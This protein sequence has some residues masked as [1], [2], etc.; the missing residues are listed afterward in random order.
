MPKLALIIFIKV[1]IPGLVK[2]RLSQT[3]CLDDVDVTLL[4]EAMFK[5]TLVAASE[6]IAD[7]I[8]IG[9]FP[10]NEFSRIKKIVD[11]VRIAENLLKP[12][13]YS[14]QTGINFDE[15]F[16]S[17]VRNSFEKKDDII[18][19]LGADLPYLH[20]SAINTAFNSLD[21]N[22]NKKR[23]VLGP[24]G[25]G[26]VYLVGITKEFSPK[27]F[28][29][30]ELFRGGVEISQFVKLCE[31]ENFEL[32]MLHPLIDIDIEEDLVSLLAFIDTK[33]VVKHYYEFHFP[34]Y[35]AQ[36]VKTLGLYIK[37][38]T[39]ETRKRKIGKRKENLF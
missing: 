21:A 15:R 5:D 2:T 4:A 34:K 33:D 20:M 36:A 32:E 1:P 13:N 31:K 35:T 3:T 18:V 27:W 38:K 24:A 6:S 23:V 29:E 17:I 7:V 14:V 8:E 22:Q 10:K 28:V 37:D 19:I 25:G 39:G 9:F 11:L 12:I 16:S 26:G 30:Y